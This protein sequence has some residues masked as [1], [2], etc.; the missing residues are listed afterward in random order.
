[1]SLSLI[2][3]AVRP[4][5]RDEGLVRQLADSV[6]ESFLKVISWDAERRMFTLP[7]SHPLLGWRQCVVDGCLKFAGG[8]GLCHACLL[9][10][11]AQDQSLAE[12]VEHARPSG[13]HV[14][15]LPCRVPGCERQWQSRQSAFCWRHLR[16][17]KELGLSVEDFLAHPMTRPL[18]SFGIC[19][20]ACCMRSREGWA[21]GYC[22]THRIQLRLSRKK[23]PDLDEEWWKLTA[24]PI[25]ENADLNVRAVPELVTWQILYG[26]QDHA[27]SI[28]FMQRR[29]PLQSTARSL[30]SA[31]PPS[32]QT[33][34]TPWSE[35]SDSLHEYANWR[36]VCPSTSVRPS[37]QNPAS[38]PRPTSTSSNGAS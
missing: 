12:Y 11:R 14:G 13:R 33:W 2:A 35:T 1:M 3:P 25:A 32:R 30:Q 34:L 19:D 4:L 28:A 22:H 9:R 36:N 26:V 37:G 5:T 7:R 8:R 23:S 10:F 6:E 38:A 18:S 29:P 20:V 24:A 16:Q 17:R 31:V 15:A 21:T 27:H